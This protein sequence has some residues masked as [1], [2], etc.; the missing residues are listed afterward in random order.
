[1]DMARTVLLGAALALL[2]S[3]ATAKMYK[4]VDES[5]AVHYSD[6]PHARAKELDLPPL[7]V[8]KNRGSERA[9]ARPARADQ[10]RKKE[11]GKKPREYETL[12]IEVP[13]NDA[14]IRANNGELAVRVKLYPRL[15]NE[16]KHRFRVVIDGEARPSLFDRSRMVVKEVDR[17]THSLQVEVVDKDGKVLKRSKPVT[18]HLLR[19]SI[20]RR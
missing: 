4:W 20:I 7:P 5:G 14:A 13:A 1:M 8:Y 9:P 10:D 6:R 12:V 16:A 15:D 17:G 2:A 18:F 19:T 11:A 3:S